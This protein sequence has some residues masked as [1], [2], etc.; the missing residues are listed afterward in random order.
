ML[1]SQVVTLPGGRTS[2]VFRAGQGPIVV[3]LHGPHGVRGRD[4]VVAELARRH[5][6][7]APL[8]PGFAEATELDDVRDVHDL[9]LHY[10]DV[11]EA[12]GL[13]GATVIGHSFG[14]MVA[15][16]VAAHFPRRVARLVLISPLGLWREEEPVPDM[17]A[18]PY[19]TIDKL[20]WKDGAPCAEMADPADEPSDPIEKQVAVA[21]ALTAVAKFVWPLPDRGLRR[22]LPR[23]TADTLIIA[24]ADDPFVPASYVGAFAAAIRG[25]RAAIIPTAGH[26]LPYEKP[27]E[28]FRLL[29]E[30]LDATV[31]AA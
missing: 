19:M 20:L 31:K 7:L 27:A 13:D 1:T 11:L 5:T 21:Q 17:F 8:A 10:D 29:D 25:A 22:R 16:E 23:M 24:G 4:P 3:W 26:M 28:V 12:L 30:F 15:A 6:V 18:V 9:A 14:A 2:K